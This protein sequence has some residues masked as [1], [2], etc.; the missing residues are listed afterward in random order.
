MTASDVR[1][2][3][4]IGIV[5]DEEGAERL[6]RGIDDRSGSMREQGV[7]ESKQAEV[8]KRERLYCW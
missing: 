2:G 4:V 8:R 7:G 5:G 3:D 6:R 1:M